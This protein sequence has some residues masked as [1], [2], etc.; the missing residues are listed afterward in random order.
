MPSTAEKR[1]QALVE[2][3]NPSFVCKPENIQ[4]GFGTL[5]ITED[6]QNAKLKKVLINKVPENSVLLKMQLFSNIHLGNTLKTVLNSET[7]VFQCC[8]FI[9]LTLYKNQ[10]HIIFIEMKSNPS[11]EMQQIINQFK[12]AS[13]FMEY[14]DAITRYFKDINVFLSNSDHIHYFRDNTY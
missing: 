4:N 9:I 14:C 1:L 5:F 11:G 7:G 13:C 10:T 2:I 6:E 3:F 12:A 8:D